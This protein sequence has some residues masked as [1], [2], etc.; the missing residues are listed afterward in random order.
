MNRMYAGVMIVALVL[1]PVLVRADFAQNPVIWAD[2]PDV[3]LIRV[4]DTYYMSSTTMHM[5]PG[6]PI[7]KSKDLVNWQLIGYAYN[8]LAD[9]E[10]L[11]LENGKTAYGQGSWASSLRYH[12]GTYYVSTFSSTSGRTHI[13]TTKDIEKGDWKEISFA[14]SLHDHSL[15]FD[16]DGRVY[17]IY[18]GGNL[19][20][21]ELKSDLTGI[22]DGGFND[23]VIRNASAVAGPNIGLNAE[24]SQMLK[25]NGKYYVMNITWPRGGMRT[26]I[27]HRADKITGPYEGRVVLQD[28]G[29]AQGCLIDTPDGKWYAM[30]F[31][32][33]GAVGR[34]PW[35]VPVKWE[36]GWPVLGIDGKAPVTLDIVDNEQGLG[37][38]VASD[39]F[40]RKPGEPLPL[41]WQW[42][43]NPDNRYWSIGQRNGY[44]RLTTGRVD[45]DVLMARNTLT[46]RTFGP[47]CSAVTK[48]EVDNMKDG[49]CAGL[50][51]LQ[52]KYGFVGVKRDG[53]NKSIVMVSAQSDKPETVET[54][55]LNQPA[56]HL[57]I[58]CDFRERTDKANFY[59]SLD[60]QTWTKIG[61]VLQ[62]SYTLP[63]FMGYRFGL[64]N[65]A[66]KETGGYV[67]FDYYHVSSQ[68]PSATQVNP[69][70]VVDDF[71]PASTNQPGRQYPQVNSEGR[72]RARIVAPE[73]QQVL[74]DIGGVKYPMS[75]GPDGAWM[76][77]S[78][79]QDEG[80]HY[81]QL[82][83]DSAQVPDPG[84]LFFYG[85]SRWGSGIEVAAKD[86]DFYALKDVPHGQIRQNLYFSKITNS[87]RRCFVYTPPF[88]DK[89]T[90]TRYPVLYLQHGG[91]EDETGWPNQGKTN[92]IMDN[93]I[94]EGKAR[95]FIIVM[96][97][98]TWSMPGRE[99]PRRVE[100][101]PWPPTGWADTFKRVLLEEIIPMIDANYRTLADQ[102]HRAMAGLSMGGMQTNAIAMENLDVF[103]HIGIF[104][105]GTVGD[106]A[107]A[108]NGVMANAQEFNKKVKL[109]F[110]SCGSK[111]RP[112]SIRAHVD[113]L[114]AAGINA[115][116]Y[117]SPETAH[118]WQT[119]RRSLY[120]FA[121]LLFRD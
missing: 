14:P 23:V 29:V 1:C 104:S 15:F 117:V 116:F 75:K 27:I 31:Q 65:F 9:N 37:N 20:L 80:F 59:Y 93:L 111:E 4:G 56:V 78:A 3:A 19:R 11:R 34:S 100:G 62:M 49:D 83:I 38:I 26:Q 25:V 119:W 63:H 35:L 91:G 48:I 82:V 121:P 90:T 115:V 7:M 107:T 18:G 51:A 52:K 72:V 88:Y 53:Q 86:Q 77:D 101:A 92:L 33:N 58:D 67:D 57:R 97:N 40:D 16:D 73:A 69:P 79:P 42:N 74:L 50:I 43:H 8:T 105:G 28:K 85:A 103:S 13:Y 44:L 41:A 17:M 2:V 87:W 66:S 60:G 81:Y 54:V 109:I 106:P 36:D 102:P 96:D 110:E 30:L 12:D 118:E 47:V 64:F 6:V 32:D 39:E 10:A 84:S 94:A 99:R 71:K 21:V 114:K 76:G 108:H 98:G 55:A 68:I 22:K 61:S 5:S 70:A 120:Q 112:D 24:G 113:Q 46:Q 45:S 89:D 95:P